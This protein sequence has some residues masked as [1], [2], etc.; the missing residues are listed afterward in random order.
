MTH[1]LKP[2]VWTWEI[3]TYFFVGGAA[4]ASAAI[5]GV[6]RLF[7]NDP[8]LVRDARMIAAAGALISPLLLISDLG[9]PARF[10]NMLRVFKLQ[11]PMSIGAWTLVAFSASVFSSLLAPHRWIGVVADSSATLF[12]LI[13]ATYTGVLIG[14]TT[15]PVWARHVSAL[16]ILFGASA[17]GTAIS[18]LELFGHRT[19]ALNVAGIGAAAIETIAILQIGFRERRFRSSRTRRSMAARLG[20]W[21]AGPIPLILRL[22]GA[23]SW[24]LRTIAACCTIVGS[25]NVRFAWMAAGK[26]SVSDT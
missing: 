24:V 3:P 19:R 4:G 6:A 10:L 16:P 7:G 8:L 5:A 11:S 14:A 12:G 25:L 26:Q 23:E 21:M 13:L 22:I 15:I 2:P 9:R 1:S 17:L 20:G 18:L